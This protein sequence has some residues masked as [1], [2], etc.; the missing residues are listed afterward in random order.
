MGLPY[1]ALTAPLLWTH[2]TPL[3]MSHLYVKG[4]PPSVIGPLDLLSKCS[5]FN[6]PIFFYTVYPSMLKKGW[7]MEDE[8]KIGAKD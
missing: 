3:Y 2:F 6:V 7:K 5:P 4:P 1:R 8:E